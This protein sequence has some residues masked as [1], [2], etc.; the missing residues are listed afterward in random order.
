MIKKHSVQI[1]CISVMPAL[2][3]MCLI[4]KNW[5]MRYVEASNVI[6]VPKCKK[7]PKRNKNLVLNVI[8]VLNVIRIGS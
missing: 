3:S 1:A 7:G 2:L 4:G 8:K 6:N 5:Q